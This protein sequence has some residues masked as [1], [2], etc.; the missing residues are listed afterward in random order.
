MAAELC[1]PKQLLLLSPSSS[2]SALRLLPSS[3]SSA[4][5]SLRSELI[6]RSLI[7]G[8]VPLA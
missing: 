8:A 6:G 5:C 4:L 7:Q 1:V 3:S 2:P